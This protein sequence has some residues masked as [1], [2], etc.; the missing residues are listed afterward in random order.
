MSLGRRF[1]IVLH[2]RVVKLGDDAGV[3]ELALLSKFGLPK[4]L[5]NCTY[6]VRE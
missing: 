5:C 4:V 1:A 6:Y 3:V 2:C